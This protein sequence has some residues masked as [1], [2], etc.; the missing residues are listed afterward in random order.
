[1]SRARGMTLLAVGL[2]GCTPTINLP[3]HRVALEVTVVRGPI[4]PACRIDMPCDDVPFVAGF[5]VR[6]GNQVVRT[7]RSD[8]AGRFRVLLA[9]GTF[10]IVPQ[11]DAP[12]LAP[13]TQGK[14]VTVTSEPVTRVRLTFDTGIR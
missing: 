13:R 9:P 5:D 7:A 14:M 11:D 12:L 4:L 2:L 6:I 8:T 3:V 10:E 1:M